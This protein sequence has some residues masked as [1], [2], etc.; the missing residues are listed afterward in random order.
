[1]PGQD[2]EGPPQYS[3]EP[4]VFSKAYNCGSC[5]F[6]CKI[7]FLQLQLVITDLSLS[8]AIN[9]SCAWRLQ[10]ISFWGCSTLLLGGPLSCRSLDNG[11]SA[12]GP[13]PPHTR[14]AEVALY[15]Q[16]SF[17]AEGSSLGQP[18]LNSE[19]RRRVSDYRCKGV[20]K[21]EAIR[22]CTEPW[23][24]SYSRKRGSLFS[25][26]WPEVM[27]QNLLENWQN[28]KMEKQPQQREIL[29]PG[30]WTT[31]WLKLWITHGTSWNLYEL[32]NS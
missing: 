28:S 5:H 4:S 10:G 29:T 26:F 21:H 17:K 6:Q 30:S 24:L 2:L 27:A 32:W 23:S 11:D 7:L 18:V 19:T 14:T 9:E 13:H 25:C 22:G 8:C 16:E 12:R 20:Q 1:M 15:L 31:K 3:L